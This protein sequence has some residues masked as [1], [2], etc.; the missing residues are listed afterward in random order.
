VL[1]YPSFIKTLTVKKGE[2]KYGVEKMEGYKLSS[3]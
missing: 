1:K 2:K 3:K